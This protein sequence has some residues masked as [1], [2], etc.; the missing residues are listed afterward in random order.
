MR[1]SRLAACALALLGALAPLTA[2]AVNVSGT[3]AGLNWSPAS[4]P[5]S[6]YALQVSR[7]NGSYREEAR[8]SGTSARVAGA[9][10]ET[11][12]VRVAAFD[13]RGRIGA[14]S[15]PS[16]S[17]TFTA[18]APPP[19]PPSGGNPVGDVDG[20][21]MTDALAY[22]ASSG[23]LSVLLVRSNGS[24][25]W[26]TI[27]SPSERGMRPVGYADVDGD[28]QGDLLWRNAKSGMNELWRMN[29]AAFTVVA[30]PDQPAEF[31][32]A[33][34]RDFSGDGRA[35]ALFHD[36]V[37]GTSELWTLNGAGRMN[38]LAVDPA[39]AGMSLAA[40]ADLDGNGAPD[41]VWH[42]RDTDALEAWRMSGA[43]PVAVFA[44]PDAPAG[45]RAAG[46]GDVN[47]DGA[48]D[49][50]WR[51]RENGERIVRVWFMDGMNAPSAGVALRAG[52]KLRVRGVV[53]VNSDGEAE[54]LVARKSGFT[55]Y[56]VDDTG[57]LNADGEME[58]A[59]QAT[60]L[61]EVPAS[62]RW[63]FLVL[64]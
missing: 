49:V 55:A 20:D 3:S 53:D 29:G 35:D 1:S 12:R 56:T 30:L 14:A 44:L 39:P 61:D 31:D 36:P 11:V 60:A 62:K 2:L 8:V 10:G 43:N 32:V 18:T 58:W 17:I 23:E 9:V 52:K 22:H 33:S 4:G 48:E 37:A 6:G 42:D 26:Q 27:G 13:S 59:T 25:E 57:T 63:R 41:L 21:G 46:V 54:L 5:V 51:S 16:D 64:E 50:A 34:F 28:G 7:N 38:V 15:T 40:V 45:A 47:G 24:R 19:P